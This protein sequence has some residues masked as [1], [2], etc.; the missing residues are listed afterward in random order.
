MSQVNATSA[1]GAVVGRAALEALRAAGI[2]CHNAAGLCRDAGLP[3]ALKATRVAEGMM[4]SAVA[5]ALVAASAG[6]KAGPA[7]GR[8]KEDIPTDDKGEGVDNVDGAMDT[9][10]PACRARR[11]RRRKKTAA[12]VAV[13]ADAS[14]DIDDA[15]ADKVKVAPKLELA[16]GLPGGG[17]VGAS[18]ARPRLFGS[19]SPQRRHAAGSCSASGAVPFQ[20]GQLA[21]V[22]GLSSR[23][24]LND[25]GVMLNSFDAASG[26]WVVLTAVNEQLRILPEKLREVPVHEQELWKLTFKAA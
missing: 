7:E 18:A 9:Q 22:S 8:S 23:P 6:K 21:I 24:D 19:R 17:A 26:R 2:A 1:S 11:R 13:V 14:E 3:Q 10:G 20:A 12:V 4:R 25:V 5:L 15:W 16:A